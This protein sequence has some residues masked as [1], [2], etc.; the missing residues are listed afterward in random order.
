MDKLFFFFMKSNL[1]LK[2]V[3]VPIFDPAVEDTKELISEFD[4]L[5]KNGQFIL[6]KKCPKI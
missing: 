5:L 1:S 3:K 2:I 4:K 6:G